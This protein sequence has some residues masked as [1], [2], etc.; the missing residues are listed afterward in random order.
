MREGCLL[1]LE[2]F[3]R[4]LG[5]RTSKKKMGKPSTLDLVRGLPK[6]GGKTFLGIHELCHRKRESFQ[7][8]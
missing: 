5:E 1:G 7:R 6:K 2:V 4:G 8:N 3:C